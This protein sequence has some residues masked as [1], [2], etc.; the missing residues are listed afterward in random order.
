MCP[1]MG[2]EPI[3]SDCA[4]KHINHCFKS[5]QSS[6]LIGVDTVFDYLRY[7]LRLSVNNCKH[8]SNITNKKGNFEFIKNRTNLEVKY[9][10][11]LSSFLVIYVLR[12]THTPLKM[13]YFN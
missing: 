12:K 11:D 13:T 2:I 9:L 7:K 5:P 6:E 4:D 3:T 10:Q 8:I 1:L